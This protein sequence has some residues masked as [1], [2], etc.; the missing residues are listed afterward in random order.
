MLFLLFVF[1]ASE[2]ALGGYTYNS[3]TGT[4]DYCTTIQA[5][6]GSVSNNNCSTV[7]VPAA[8]IS[9]S[10]N[11]FILLTGIPVGNA[12]SLT[13]SQTSISLSYSYVR[14][15]IASDPAFNSTILADGTA[16]QT[17]TI[18]IT[19]AEEGGTFTVTP[20]TKTGFDSVTFYGPDDQAT[21]LYVDDTVGWIIMA[22]SGAVI[23]Y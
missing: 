3:N 17:L 8:A 10:G 15:A 23:N 14:K 11:D 1:L 7:K 21:F 5:Q 18:F 22:E 4:R 16:G 6:T 20:T 9:E 2:I 13:T 12:T 19:E